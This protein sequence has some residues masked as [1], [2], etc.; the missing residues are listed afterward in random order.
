MTKPM[1]S[2]GA[3]V[4]L[5]YLPMVV[6]LVRDPIASD[7][8]YEACTWVV[9]A[10]RRSIPRAS[11]EARSDRTVMSHGESEYLDEFVVV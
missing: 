8:L 5:W 11:A 1:G 2:L 9:A 10:A 7:V 6:G 3:V 4:V